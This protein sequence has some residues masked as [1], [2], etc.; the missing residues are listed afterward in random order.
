MAT[1]FVISPVYNAERYIQKCIDSVQEQVCPLEINIVHIIIDDGSTDNTH[2]IINAATHTKL[3]YSIIHEWAEKN[4]GTITSHL[5]GI[6]EAEKYIDKSWWYPHEYASFNNVVVHLDGDD[7][8]CSNK[9]LL[10][11]AKAH[12]DPSCLV[13][14]GNYKCLSGNKSVCRPT[15]NNFREQILTG[16][17]CYSHPR[18]FKLHLA[19]YIKDEDLRDS[20]GNYFT[21]AP[22]V[23]LFLPMLEMAGVDRVRFINKEL[24][25]YNDSNPLNEDKCK[26]NDQVRCAIEISKKEPYKRLCI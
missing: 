18:T 21:A 3:K 10:E 19:S 24:V 5:K 15:A 8:F 22:D 6:R 7:W 9:A 1:I 16:G 13:T 11:I 25:E 14:Y 12:L 2:N 23:A 4:K 26:L 20:A 17:W